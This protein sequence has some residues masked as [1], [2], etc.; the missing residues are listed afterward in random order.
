MLNG[1]QERSHPASSCSGLVQQKVWRCS[2]GRRRCRGSLTDA[3]GTLSVPLAITSGRASLSGCFFSTGGD[4]DPNSGTPDRPGVQRFASLVCSQ[5]ADQLLPVCARKGRAA[6]ADHRHIRPDWR[7]ARHSIGMHRD[8]EKVPG[9]ANTTLDNNWKPFTIKCG[10]AHSQYAGFV[11]TAIFWAGAP[12]CAR[13][14]NNAFQVD[15]E[16]G[17]RP[18]SSW[19]AENQPG[20]TICGTKKVLNAFCYSGFSIWPL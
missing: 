7:G 2:S 19:T 18:A 1:R 20:G 16:K 15:W 12:G 4:P 5:P 13:I 6:G 8:G 17:K 11:E 14:P 9:V 3:D 10:N